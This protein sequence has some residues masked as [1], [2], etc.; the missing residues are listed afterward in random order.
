MMI[1]TIGCFWS[2]YCSGRPRCCAASSRIDL[3]SPLPQD[4]AHE[5]GWIAS[6]PL[7]RPDVAFAENVFDRNV[8]PR[9]EVVMCHCS[10]RC[11]V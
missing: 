4:R 9:A 10:C 3:R 7:L 6:V 8:P 2:T 1:V 11:Q 5:P